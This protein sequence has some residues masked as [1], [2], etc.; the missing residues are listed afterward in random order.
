MPSDLDQLPT[1][2]RRLLCGVCTFEVNRLYARTNG[3]WL[4]L[5][6]E[7][8]EGAGPFPHDTAALRTWGFRP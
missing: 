4:V 3:Y 6:Q 1:F 2:R 7:A 5:D 8:P